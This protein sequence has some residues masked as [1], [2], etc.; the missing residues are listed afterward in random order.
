[1]LQGIHRFE[2]GNYF[3]ETA[4]NKAN[5]LNTSFNWRLQTVPS[6]GHSNNNMAPTAAEIFISSINN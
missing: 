6:V 3:Y 5:Q 1:M 2:R 4:R